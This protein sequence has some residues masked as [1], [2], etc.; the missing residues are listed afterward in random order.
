M[1]RYFLLISLVVFFNFEI[2]YAISVQLP[3]ASHPGSDNYKFK[4]VEKKILSLDGRRIEV[5]YPKTNSHYKAPCFVYGHGYLASSYMYADTFIHLAKKGIAVVYPQYEEDALDSYFRRMADDFNRLAAAGINFLGDRIDRDNIHYAGHS[6][7]GQIALTAAG[8]PNLRREYQPISILLFA[9]AGFDY[10]YIRN[11]DTNLP[12]SIFWGEKDKI[13][14][15]D[16]SRS[17]YE[18]LPSEHKQLI[19]VRSYDSG[20]YLEA[21]HLFMLTNVGMLGGQFSPTPFHYHGVWKWMIGA[22]ND[23]LNGNQKKEKYLYGKEAITTGIPGFYHKA[24]RSWERDPKR[25]N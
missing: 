9:P 6:L 2:C 21:D 5:Y 7:G 17:I 12:V 20:T 22:V 8:A 24:M 25:A 23:G 10:G 1:S 19:E 13:I 16:T 11:I 14:D 18:L 15:L 3:S 4:E